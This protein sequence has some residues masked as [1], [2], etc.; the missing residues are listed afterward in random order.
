[1]NKDNLERVEAMKRKKGSK[2]K[3]HKLEGSVVDPE[4]VFPDPDPTFPD[5]SGSGSCFGSYMNFL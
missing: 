4:L 5:G 2:G 1:M 3:K